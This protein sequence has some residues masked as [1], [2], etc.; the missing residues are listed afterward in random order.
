M[1]LEHGFGITGNCLQ[2]Y[3]LLR[4]IALLIEQLTLHSNMFR[5][6]PAVISNRAIIHNPVIDFFRSMRSM[7]NQLLA[8][9]R[10]ELIALPDISNWRVS[11]DST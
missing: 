5:K 6:L 10:M 11:L 9:L 2:N 4:L 3:F 1:E 8:S 7:A